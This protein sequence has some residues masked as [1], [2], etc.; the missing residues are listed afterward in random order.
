MTATAATK[1]T[2]VYLEELFGT[3]QV[4]MK[5]IAARPGEAIEDCLD[6]YKVKNAA[7]LFQG[8]PRLTNEDLE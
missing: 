5:R 4:C 8:W 2:A 1:I 3:Q 6:R 7:M